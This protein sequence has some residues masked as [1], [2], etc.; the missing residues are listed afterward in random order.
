MLQLSV[1]MC[2][3]NPRK[4]Y[5]ERALKALRNQT[6]SKD[7]WELLVVDNASHVPLASTWDLS[8][9]PNGRH[10]LERELGTAFARC[11]G[12]QDAVADTLIFVDDDNVLHQEYLS[13]AMQIEHDWP[14]LG[15]WG[16]GVTLPELEVDPPEHLKELLPYLAIRET[17]ST[18][19]SN[20]PSCDDS[21]PWGAGMCVRKS[22]AAEYCKLF[23]QSSFCITG[24]RGK[25]ALSG[26][27]A[28]REI[29]IV[30]CKNGYGMGV[31]PQLRITHLI[32]KERVA[33]KYML[34]LVA[35]IKA[36]DMI[37]DFKWKRKVPTKPTLRRLL[38]ALTERGFRKKMS[39][40]NLRA[41]REAER[42]IN[43]TRGL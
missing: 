6:L 37:L 1:I 21:H 34:E 16:S 25:S 18:Y 15:V 19:W 22:V 24:R 42:I 27:G 26:G 41:S 43:E 4:D 14:W 11:R 38:S 29:C 8:W 39:F 30:A 3:H 5:F 13:E 20:V 28:D 9:H 40:A 31:F 17:T 12:M 23:K 36:F 35:A 33:E 32:P 2:A 7:N 10:L